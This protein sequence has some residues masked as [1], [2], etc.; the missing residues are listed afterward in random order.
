[1]NSS[2]CMKEKQIYKRK[3]EVLLYI[4]EE[5]FIKLVVHLLNL[6]VVFPLNWKRDATETSVY[7]GNILSPLVCNFT[8]DIPLS[9]SVYI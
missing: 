1:M 9:I 2:K 3:M 6:S 7:A 5:Q 8:E 4:F